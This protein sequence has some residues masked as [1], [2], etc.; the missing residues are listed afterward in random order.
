MY[1]ARWRACTYA[2]EFKGWQRGLSVIDINKRVY[3]AGTA[4][5]RGLGEQKRCFGEK[6]E[7][8]KKRM[9][10]VVSFIIKL[11]KQ[12]NTRAPEC[13]REALRIILDTEPTL[14]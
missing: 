9:E 6:S 2:G 8:I 14:I 7:I 12:T 3:T 10:I 5:L 13:F 11:L 4:T 1:P